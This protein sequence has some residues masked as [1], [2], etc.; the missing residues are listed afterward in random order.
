MNVMCITGLWPHRNQTQFQHDY[1]SPVRKRPI[2]ILVAAILFITP[3]K[4]DVFLTGPGNIILKLI[5]RFH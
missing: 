1:P 2:T 3:I 4:R 5:V